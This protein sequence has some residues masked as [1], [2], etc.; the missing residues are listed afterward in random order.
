MHS[1]QGL[2]GIDSLSIPWLLKDTGR[3][4]GRRNCTQCRVGAVRTLRIPHDKSRTK[5]RRIFA[6]SLIA[7]DLG[8]LLVSSAIWDILCSLPWWKLNHPRTYERKSDLDPTQTAAK[9]YLWS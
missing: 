1:N 2:S 7:D 8:T 5:R 3:P 4:A 6:G 9:R